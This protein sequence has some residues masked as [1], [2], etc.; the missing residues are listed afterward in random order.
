M[1]VIQEPP[2]WFINI[3]L[4]RISPPMAS[5]RV[6]VSDFYERTLGSAL[7]TVMRLVA[8]RMVFSGIYFLGTYPLVSGI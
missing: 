2:Q 6:I 4:C 5:F 7:G 3:L 8:V 1:R